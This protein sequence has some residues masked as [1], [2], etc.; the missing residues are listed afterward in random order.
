MNKQVVQSEMEQYRLLINSFTIQLKVAITTKYFYYTI[1]NSKKAFLRNHLDIF[2]TRA[3]KS[4]TT[5]ALNRATYVNKMSSFLTSTL[6]NRIIKIL[7][8]I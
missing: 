5:V 8:K 7:S 4:N 6:T 3:D 2:I 1:L